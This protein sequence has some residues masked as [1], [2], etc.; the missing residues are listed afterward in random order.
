MTDRFGAREIVFA[1]GSR[2]ERVLIDSADPVNYHQLVTALDQAPPRE[3]DG[4]LFLPPGA[5]GPVPLVVIVPGSLSVAPSHLAHAEDV[6]GLGAAAFVL[7]PFGGRSV[8]STVANQ[9]QFSFAASAL[10]VMRTVVALGDRPEIDATRVNLQGHSRGG[11][12]V[13][14]A[15]MRSLHGGVLADRPP[16]RGVLAAYPWCGHQPLDPTIGPTEVLVLHGDRDEW[17]SVQQAQG[18]VQAIR[19]AGGDATIRIVAGAHHS[20]DRREPVHLVEDASVAPGAPTAYLTADGS[21]VHPLTGE[22]DASLVD[23]DL[24]LSGIRAGY[25]VRGARIGG[26]GAQPDDFRAAM[27]AFHRRTLAR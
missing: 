26:E 23:R 2:G 15:A 20:F 27:L 12:A 5:A 9:A 19:L 22:A 16:I 17:C 13:L 4:Q 6:V 3:I 18:F 24:M 7:D 14:L 10:D 1:D 21:F 25:G 11:S 8:T